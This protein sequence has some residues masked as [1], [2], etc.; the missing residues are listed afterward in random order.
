MHCSNKRGYFMGRYVLAVLA[1]AATFAFA[2]WA[3]AT[4]NGFGRYIPGVFAGPASEIV[5]P[6]PGFY[7]QHSTFYYTA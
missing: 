5:P 3:G 7:W 1:V 6:V 4:E 2:L